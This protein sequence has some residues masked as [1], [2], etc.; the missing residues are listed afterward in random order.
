MP[1]SSLHVCNIANMAYGYAK[2]LNA[3]GEA[4]R[5]LCH[6]IKHVMSQPEWDDLELDPADFPDENNFFDNKSVHLRGYSRPEWF[7][8]G[9]V[10]TA[11]Q[12][13]IALSG[14]SQGT[15]W[16][17]KTVSGACSL[18]AEACSHLPSPLKAKL[19]R[20]LQVNHYPAVTTEASTHQLRIASE[21][22][23]NE[24]MERVHSLLCSDA[25]IQIEQIEVSS[26]APYARF[27][28]QYVKPQDVL[29]S[30]ASAPISAMLLGKNPY[31]AVELG[32]I[33][34]LPFEPNLW[35]QMIKVGFQLANH[36]IITNPDNI[37]AASRLGLESYTFC[38]HPVDEDVFQP[39]DG[40][41][42][43]RHEL[44]LKYKA[45]ALFLAPARQNWP[46][47][48]NNIMIEGFAK[49]VGK[50]LN[51][52][53]LIPSWGPDISKGQNLARR[54]GVADRIH[55]L[56]PLSER[57]LVKYYQ[58]VDAVLDQFI[59]G[60][61][62]LIT[63]KAMSCGRPV[64]CAYD[65]AINSWCF[66]VRPPLLAGRNADDISDHLLQFVRNPEAMKRLG[67][68]ARKWILEHHSSS[69]CVAAMNS[70]AEAA[71]EHFF[72]T[73]NTATVRAAASV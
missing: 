57:G 22:L 68:A 72:R 63:P 19:K 29:F 17:T 21:R 56:A 52:H 65:D 3:S 5:V 40:D 25:T 16:W 30:Y 53:L 47:K 32:T 35:G 13:V 8:Q 73:S 41:S 49:A 71:K 37:N 34:D 2:M 50:G 9:T 44:L 39:V 4:A 24:N 58:A 12:I 14:G 61:F 55:W 7:A 6:D 26:Y 33:R 43:L 60:V 18:G 42:A 36:V 67:E 70:A 51:A 10:S 20:F 69:S 66:P 54:L 31:V 38:P 48:G 27:L 45:D 23:I 15:N 28:D 46:L 1:H 62:G 11:E 59:L 64:L